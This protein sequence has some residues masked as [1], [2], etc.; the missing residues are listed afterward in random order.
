VA[1]IVHHL[2]D[3]WFESYLREL[4]REQRLIASIT[5]EVGTGG[6]MS[7][8]IAPVRV[9]PDGGLGFEKQAPTVSYGNHADDFLTTL[10]RSEEVA[11]NDQVLVLTSAA[12][13]ALEQ[14][15]TWDTI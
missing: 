3:A 7:R 14:T 2:D 5:S 9:A 11:E 12:Q 4:S 8:S 6:D 10:R 15:G 13:T 1:T